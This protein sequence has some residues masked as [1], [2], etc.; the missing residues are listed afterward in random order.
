MGFYHVCVTWDCDVGIKILKLMM[1]IVCKE[2][3]QEVVTGDM[4][5]V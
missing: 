5:V 1:I 4:R 2:V 3:V